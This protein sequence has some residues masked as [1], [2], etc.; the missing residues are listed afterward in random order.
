[1]PW[2]TVWRVGGDLWRK[3]CKS[4]WRFEAPLTAALAARWPD[5]LPEVVAHGD[6]WLL[7]R[8]AGPV[9]EK[10]PHAHAV[11]LD[12]VAR[13]GELQRGEAE[14]VHEHLDRGVPDQRTH[15]LPAEYA[16]M[17]ERDELPWREGER[18][19]FAAF[20]P[21]FAR[22]CDELGDLASI[23]HDDL[24]MHNVYEGGRVLDWGDSCVSHPFFSLVVT[25]RFVPDGQDAIRDAYLEG[26]GGD[27]ETFEHALRVG[28]IAHLFKW[29]RFRDVLPD[30]MLADYDVWMRDFL[31]PAAAQ[32]AE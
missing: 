16:E 21:T 14:H 23:N 5:R 18:A 4:I 6:D 32:V 10:L 20:E 13:Y 7:L 30:A 1:M 17:I 2:S 29:I 31:D 25:F 22:W 26:Y 27:R 8:D 28:R 15:L 9:V 12:A 24:H 11:W 19:A 3:R